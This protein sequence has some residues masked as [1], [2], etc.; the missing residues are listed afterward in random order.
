MKLS[1]ITP[2]KRNALLVSGVALAA[3]ALGVYAAV[4]TEN[5]EASTQAG[6]ATRGQTVSIA[7]VQPEPFQRRVAL[8]GEARP[9]RDVRVFAP[10]Q[11]VRVL[12]LLVEQG[13]YVKKGQALA[14]LDTALI[15]AQGASQLAAVKEAEAAEVRTVGAFNRAESIKDS[16]ALSAEQLASRYADAEAA[17][18]RLAQARAVY[19]E[20]TARTQGGYVRAPSAGLVIER[21]AVLGQSVDGQT[22]FRIV[23]DNALE[24]AA[25]VAEADMLALKV[26]QKATFRMVDEGQVTAILRRPPPAIDSRTRTGTALFDLPRDPRL[27]AGMFL[28]GQVELP[29]VRA[30]A[31]P[32]QAVSY[33]DGQ[34]FVFVIDAHDRARRT[35]VTLGDRGGDNVM[36]KNGLS[37][38]ARVA[39]AGAAFLQ[40]GDLVRPATPVQPAEAARPAAEKGG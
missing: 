6:D 27:R 16:G 30:L 2:R 29:Q 38:G 23:A 40:D 15:E 12:E 8:S 34:A 3:S 35:S 39:L 26:G 25:E 31:V 24:V 20:W 36:I 37:A 9:R 28:R 10:A 18:A 33:A 4:S 13:D 17:K 7:I 32:Q 22:L 11:G 14:R 21:P 1:Q 5:V 19:D